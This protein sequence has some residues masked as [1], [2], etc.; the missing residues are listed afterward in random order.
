LG[1]GPRWGGAQPK[2][3]NEAFAT[4]D[5]CAQCHS[6]S[7]TATAMR[8]ALGEDVS[9]H[10]TWQ[11]TVMANS[12]RD[13]YWRAQVAKECAEDPQRSSEVQALCLRCHAPM[14]HHSLRLGQKPSTTVAQAANDPLAQDGVSCTA[15][16]Q[17][18]ARGLGEETT[19]SGKGRIGRSRVIY[20]PYE[21][22][23][24]APMLGVSRYAPQHGAH[25]QRSA[26]CATCHT[27]VT[28]HQGERFP[29]Q[30]PYLEWRN[31][32]FSDEDGAT[33]TSRTCQQCHM[34][35]IGATRIARDPNGFDYLLQARAPYRAHAFVGGNA[36]LLDLLRANRDELAVE[37]SAAALQRMA[38]ATRRQLTTATVDVAI[39][40]I[41]RADDELQFS[42]R[43]RNK[44]GHKFP[45]GYPSRRAWLHVRVQNEAGVVFES[46][47]Y[48]DDGRIL[49]VADPL[50][51]EHVTR[52]ETPYDVLVWELVAHDPDGEPTT[53]LTR[54]AKRGKDNRLL[55]EG[56]SRG[57]PHA[58]E[59]APVGIGND[60][61]FTAGGDTV[62]VA[63][64]YEADAPRATV[65][66]WVH[67]QTIPPHWVEPLR[68]VDADECRDFV[69]M[70]DAADRAPETIAAEQRSERL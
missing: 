22:P 51:H 59:T 30:T 7:A 31:S 39:G 12:F 42:V 4:A 60:F 16:H 62:H 45:T 65:S 8:S 27:L 10:A 57:G 28:T 46:G 14:H 25:V 13:P 9:P 38:L 33:A 35:D 53:S 2:G 61:D 68:D 21:Q 49:G 64:P 18:R 34:P 58:D 23:D 15:C 63:F 26:L 24:G 5:G 29:E 20:G 55:P 66:V 67:Y 70:Y 52:I 6:A 32:V 3:R 48:R 40:E 69:R 19:W 36:F 37:A 54:M 56:W 17:I 41:T 47:G 50:D 1:A 43:V 44:T 11:A